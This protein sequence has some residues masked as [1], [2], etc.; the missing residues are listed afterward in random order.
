MPNQSRA[1]PTD[2]AAAKLQVGIIRNAALYSGCAPA[3][4][5]LF[6][7]LWGNAIKKDIARGE[8]PLRKTLFE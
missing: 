6:L 2:Y 5:E 3:T 8:M 4:A 1:S 7:N